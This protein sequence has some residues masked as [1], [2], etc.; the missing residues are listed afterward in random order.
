MKRTLI[1]A[2]AGWVCGVLVLV[3]FG[4]WAGYTH[5]GDWIARAGLLPGWEAAGKGAFVYTAYY[6]WLTGTIGGIIG[7]TAGLGSWLVRP[8]P[9]VKS[10]VSDH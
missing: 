3:G 9:P 8:S 6:W 7:G 4:A 10:G 1:G 5:G 2:S